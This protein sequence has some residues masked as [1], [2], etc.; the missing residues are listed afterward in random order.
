MNDSDD[1]TLF[2]RSLLSR[3]HRPSQANVRSTVHRIG[4]FT[5]PRLPSGRRT[6]SRSHFACSVTIAGLTITHGRATGSSPALPSEGGGILNL[7]F[8]IQ[9]QLPEILDRHLPP[10]LLHCGLSNGWLITVWIAYI[11]S[12]ADHRKSPVQ[13]W[14]QEL[15]HTIET[16]IGQRIRPVELGVIQQTYIL[17]HRMS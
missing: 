16:L 13:A 14:A 4:N 12:R 6:I 5:H 11:L 9:L 17:F 2:T 7:G 15:Q 1:R 10:H 3:R 8:L